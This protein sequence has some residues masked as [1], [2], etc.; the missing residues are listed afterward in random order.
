MQMVEI[1]TDDLLLRP[2]RP[3]DVADVRRAGRDPEP[4]GA[5]AVSLAVCD[6]GDGTLLGGACLNALDRSRGTATFDYWVAPWA[7]SAVVATHAGRALLGWAF[8]RLGLVRADWCA[9]VGDHPARLTALRLGFRMIGVRPASSGQ[10]EE[11]LAALVPGDLTGPGHDVGPAVRRQATVFGGDPPTLVAGPVSLRPPAA[12]D[13]AGLRAAYRD[14]EIIRWYGVP[15]QATDADIHRFLVD[16]VRWQWA[17]GEEAVFV[18]AGPDDAFTGIADLRIGDD[19]E[20][21]EVGYA[22]LPE[23][24]GRGHATAALRALTR[25]GVTQLGLARIQWQAEVGNDASRRTA[26]KAGFTVEGVLRSGYEQDGRRRDCWV[27]SMLAREMT[28]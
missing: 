23:A 20:V 4:V 1:R 10:P 6:A 27:A 8:E 9:V 24:R 26:E 11:W 17:R 21:G 18:V 2:W 5:D 28:A 7:R 19:P 22:M 25:W 14:P 15:E 3:A 13:T 16:T 12:R